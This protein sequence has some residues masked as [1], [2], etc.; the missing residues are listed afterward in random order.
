[1][2][3]IL[4]IHCTAVYK[5]FTVKKIFLANVLI[6]GRVCFLSMM[7][8][9]Q[10]LLHKRRHTGLDLVQRSLSLLAVSTDKTTSNRSW[11]LGRELMEQ[12]R[13][14]DITVA[15]AHSSLYALPRKVQKLIGGSGGILP[16]KILEFYSLPGRFRG[17][18]LQRSVCH[19]RQTRV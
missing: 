13:S 6:G 9:F 18:I 7:H 10:V 5:G 14:Q 8:I 3:A 4:T 1:M 19:L 16:Q 11:Q 17:H 12:W 15:R 2:Y